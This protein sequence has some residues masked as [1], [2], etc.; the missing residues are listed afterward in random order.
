MAPVARTH[1]MP[2]SFAQQRLWFLEQLEGESALYNVPLPLH[3]EGDLNE[4]AL[5]T[6]IRELV[7]RHEVLRTTFTEVDGG[8]VQIIGAVPSELKIP[9]IDLSEEGVEFR[10]TQV[11]RLIGQLAE[12]TFSLTQ[13]PLFR[14]HLLKL[15]KDEHVLVLI[16]HHIVT[17]GWSNELL[18]QE[19]GKLYEAFV[20]GQPSPL[21]EL[22]VQYADYATWQRQWLQGDRLDRQ[23]QYW[24]HRLADAPSLLALQTDYP[25]PPVQ[26]YRGAVRF[27]ELP[28]GVS[29]ALKE[30]SGR[31][32]VTLFMTL[33]TAYKTLLFRESGEEDLVVGFPVAN[34]NRSEIEGL[35]GFFVNT[36]V[37]RTDL[38]G[39]PTFQELLQQVKKVALEAYAN[40]DVPFEKLV[41]ELQPERNRSYSPLCQVVFGFQQ[42]RPASIVCQ[43]VTMTFCEVER[44]SSKF[45][46]TF[47]VEERGDQLVGSVEY[48]TD[49]FAEKTIE[50]MIDQYRSILESVIENPKQRLREI[51][52]R[53]DAALV[54]EELDELFQ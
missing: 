11:Q 49:L 52:L 20:K 36:L 24:T 7:L 12:Q 42:E 50:R 39:N 43:D 41:E 6:A 10:S 16:L 13:G 4:Q 28:T 9:V 40:Q 45:D 30:L 1:A 53:S 8:V 51:Q 37:L 14:S 26:S 33:L 15:R 2:A 5:T 22:P 31:E 21:P 38:S 25:R 34:R 48:S 19:L 47:F 54:E 3:I 35:I 46:L 18:I 17:D 29:S 32:G 27:F 44:K 23:L